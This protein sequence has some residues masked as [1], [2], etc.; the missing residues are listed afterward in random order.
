MVELNKI[1]NPTGKPELDD[2]F[3]EEDEKPISIPLADAN[4][5]KNNIPDQPVAMP[6]ATINYEEERFDIL[7]KVKKYF[8]ISLLVLL[9]LAIV[10]GLSWYRQSIVGWAQHLNFFANR[11]TSGVKNNPVESDQKQ[12]TNQIAPANNIDINNQVPVQVAQPINGKVDSDS[13][14]LTDDEEAT[15]GTNL[16]SVDTDNDGLFD[17]EEVKVYHTNP[18]NPDTDGDG[19][20]D[21]YEVIN[22]MNPRGAGTLEQLPKN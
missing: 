3:A 14:G 11:N 2:I 21:G 20:Q 12:A 15:L 16:Q 7:G 13:D 5:T 4:R 1:N 18:L 17:R 22:H 8:R 9:V 19:Y 6:A 10:G